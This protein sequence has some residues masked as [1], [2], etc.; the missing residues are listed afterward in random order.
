MTD[1]EEVEGIVVAVEDAFLPDTAKLLESRGC[2]V[3]ERTSHE[4]R[5]ALA[6]VASIARPG[7]AFRG[8]AQAARVDVLPSTSVYDDYLR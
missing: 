6:C 8:N 2:Q 4:Q 5:H 7:I 1:E 3:R